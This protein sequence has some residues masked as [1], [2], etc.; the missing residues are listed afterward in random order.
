MDP[1]KV[2]AHS[3]SKTNRS[4]YEGQLNLLANAPGASTSPAAYWN[5]VFDEYPPKFGN[6]KQ[7]IE[8]LRDISPNKVPSESNP[9]DSVMK[10][11]RAITAHREKYKDNNV[12]TGEIPA[13]KTLQALIINGNLS[14]G[15]GAMPQR[16]QAYLRYTGLAFLL[17]E[18]KYRKLPQYWILHF[19]QIQ[20][21]A[22]ADR[23]SK[24]PLVIA[25]IAGQ[26]DVIDYLLDQG[27]DVNQPCPETDGHGSKFDTAA[28]Y[29][30][31]CAMPRYP[32][33]Q[34]RYLGLLK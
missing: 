11:L 14:N 18:P 7:I 19:A 6:W 2:R 21:A 13:A 1:S 29:H 27:A 5:A 30:L 15:F 23:Y 8:V 17:M 28:T 12:W 26:L 33:L 25:I 31:L 10:S 9:Y 4:L 3:K 20:A 34:D 16:I 32:H 22:P 24:T